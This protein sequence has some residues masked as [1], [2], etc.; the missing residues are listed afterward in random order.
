MI[1]SF[2]ECAGIHTSGDDSA[3]V[4]IPDVIKQYLA[5]AGV[6]DAVPWDGRAAGD[7]EPYGY[8]QPSN[9]RKWGYAGACASVISF[10]C[11]S[12]GPRK[13]M[14]RQSVAHH[15]D[16]NATQSSSS[17][18]TEGASIAGGT[19]AEEDWRS[20]EARRAWEEAQR[21]EPENVMA[22]EDD[23]QLP[24]DEVSRRKAHVPS[25]RE[26]SLLSLINQVMQPG[27]LKG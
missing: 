2:S 10:S 6:L 14:A 24:G 12:K 23:E 25:W 13:P 17:S 4:D 8:L 16:E 18:N 3:P 21:P 7:D 11:G 22:A 26:M 1:S 9:P 20:R 5:S 19:V 15:A 27:H